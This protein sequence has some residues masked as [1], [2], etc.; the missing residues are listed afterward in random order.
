MTVAQVVCGFQLCLKTDATKMQGNITE[1]CPQHFSRKCANL[2][3]CHHLAIAKW[4][5]RAKKYI[6]TNVRTLLSQVEE[7]LI[8]IQILFPLPLLLFPKWQ[9][10]FPP[11]H[12]FQNLIKR[13]RNEAWMALWPY[14]L[15][16]SH[17][18]HNSIWHAGIFYQGFFFFFTSGGGRAGRS[19][20]KHWWY[21]TH[22]DT[23]AITPS[24]VF[25]WL[26]DCCIMRF[27]LNEREFEQ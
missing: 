6:W 21:N 17:A 12:P 9:M 23:H 13:C 24:S 1:H 14:F 2:A 25:Q 26:T 7:H 19:D 18:E 15:W 20:P 8:C 5:K 3:Y 27:S 22:S 4:C 11:P 16:G 10:V